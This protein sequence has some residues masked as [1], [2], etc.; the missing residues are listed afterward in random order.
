[1]QRNETG[2]LPCM[3]IN[4]RWAE[5]LNVKLETTDHLE[6]NMSKLLNIGFGNDFFFFFAFYPKSRGNKNKNKQLSLHQTITLSLCKGNH[7]QNETRGIEENNLQ[8][9]YPVR[10]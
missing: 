2:P 6:E 4:S 3:Q 8:S 9:V 7:Q 1:M 10:G 5:I